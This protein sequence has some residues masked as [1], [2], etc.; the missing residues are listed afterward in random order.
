MDRAAG[1]SGTAVD[2]LTCEAGACVVWVYT[3]ENGVG[4]NNT[5]CM[6]ARPMFGKL[7]LC[8]PMGGSLVLLLT[9]QSKHYESHCKLSNN[10]THQIGK[11]PRIR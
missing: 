9:I 5:R 11:P 2:G 3:A 1:L 6:T 10:D 7:T 8:V 4:C